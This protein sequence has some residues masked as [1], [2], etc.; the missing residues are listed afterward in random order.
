[1][2]MQIFARLA[3]TQSPYS[4]ALQ[5]NAAV[6]EGFKSLSS[7][8]YSILK[9]LKFLEFR[10]LLFFWTRNVSKKCRKDAMPA[11]QH[12]AGYAHGIAGGAAS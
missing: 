9:P 10:G 5:A 1:M 7:R 4:G 11:I 3:V 2:K 6:K 12:D 8:H